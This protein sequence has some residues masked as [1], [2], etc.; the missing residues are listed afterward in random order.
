[1]SLDDAVSGSLR[2]LRADPK[3]RGAFARVV[4]DLWRSGALSDSLP[5]RRPFHLVFRVRGLQTRRAM[6]VGREH[7]WGTYHRSPSR[8]RKGAWWTVGEGRPWGEDFAGPWILASQDDAT[9]LF[10]SPNYCT[11]FDSGP[12]LADYLRDRA[13]EWKVGRPAALPLSGFV[14]EAQ[15]EEPT[16]PPAPCPATLGPSRVP[17]VL[18]AA[19]AGGHAWGRP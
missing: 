10:M 8:R 6:K 14:W 1:M 7:P 13:L 16:P 17:C 5:P 4:L 18:T 3:D 11:R 15:S 2:A 19:H 9:R 12:G